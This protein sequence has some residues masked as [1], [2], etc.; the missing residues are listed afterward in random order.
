[1]DFL[2]KNED[3]AVIYLYR[4]NRLRRYLSNVF[5]KKTRIAASEKILKVQKVKIV[6]AE[7]MTKLKVLDQEIEN[8]KKMVSQLENHR[9]LSVRYEDY[10]ADGESIS[11]HNQRVWLIQTLIRCPPYLACR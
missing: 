6:P 5:L 8:E 10:F 2:L 4:E 9:L 3:I 1:V 11:T 7:M